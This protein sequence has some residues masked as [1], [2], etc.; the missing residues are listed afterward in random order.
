[1]EHGLP[2]GDLVQGCFGNLFLKD[3]DD[4]MREAEV[5]YGRFVDD[6]RVFGNSRAQVDRHLRILEQHLHRKG[7]SLNSSKT[8]ILEISSLAGC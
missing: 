2:T 7:L 3:L 4:A 8:E 5:P 1:M 6:L